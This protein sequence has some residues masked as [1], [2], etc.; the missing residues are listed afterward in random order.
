MK[1]MFDLLMDGT[2]HWKWHFTGRVTKK[3]F[4]KNGSKSTSETQIFVSQGHSDTGAGNSEY[5]L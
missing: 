3:N 4:L 5:S 2:F 1:G